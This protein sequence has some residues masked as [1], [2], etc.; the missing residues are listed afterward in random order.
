MESQHDTLLKDDRQVHVMQPDILRDAFLL[1]LLRAL[2]VSL[3]MAAGTSR[4]AQTSLM[5]SKLMPV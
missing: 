4:E 1:Y 3:P 2:Q 5:L